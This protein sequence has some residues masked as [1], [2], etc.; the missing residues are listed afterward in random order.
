[1]LDVRR[2]VAAKQA[3]LA[4]HASQTSGGSDLRTVALLSRLP[5][6]V[7]RRV[8]G[9]EWFVEID[10]PAAGQPAKNLFPSGS[11]R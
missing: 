10:A 6:P 11:E 4:A 2:F 5:R 8:L 7:A 3:A 1:V 9:R